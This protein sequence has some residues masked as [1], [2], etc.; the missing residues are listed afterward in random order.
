MNEEDQLAKFMERILQLKH[1]NDGKF[2]F[3]IIYPRELKLLS[4]H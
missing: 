4:K 2:Y 3:L 1:L